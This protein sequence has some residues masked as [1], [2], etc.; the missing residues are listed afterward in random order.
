MSYGRFAIGA[1]SQQWR[2]AFTV[3]GQ[4]KIGPLTA[5]EPVNPAEVDKPAAIPDCPV[6]LFQVE[7]ALRRALAE[8]PAV[9]ARTAF[10]PAT[11]VE[12][13]Q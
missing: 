5:V 9:G 13:E 3:I 12:A 4:L 1:D 11:P 10:H 2:S 7:L 8:K 6:S